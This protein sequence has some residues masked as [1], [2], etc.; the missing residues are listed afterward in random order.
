MQ[1]FEKLVGI[2]ERTGTCV[3]IILCT[4][5]HL[6]HLIPGHPQAHSNNDAIESSQPEL[7]T[8][9]SCKLIAKPRILCNSEP[10]SL[11]QQ[12]RRPR[13]CAL[14]AKL[15][16]KTS[17]S[18]VWLQESLA[19]AFQ[20]ES[21]SLKL[22]FLV[23]VFILSQIG[24]SYRHNYRGLYGMSLPSNSV[25]MIFAGHVERAKGCRCSP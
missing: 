15:R 11:L 22:C 6:L 13:C 25:H 10:T 8:L 9:K 1:G 3:R 21:I 12:H 5:Y 16:A 17:S 18:S 2:A 4:V 14:F 20:K 7:Q 23:V 19:R 24:L